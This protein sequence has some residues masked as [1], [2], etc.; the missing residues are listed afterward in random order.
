MANMQQA[1]S[2]RQNAGQGLLV[3][4][5]LFIAFCLLTPAA[6]A[7]VGNYEG[8]PVAS[9][10]VTLENT[11]PD[12]AAQA[13]FKSMLKIVGGSEYSAVKAR[14]SLHDLFASGRVASARV[15]IDETQTGCGRPTPIRVRFIVQRQIVIAG[16]TIRIAAT[17][18]TPVARD[19]NRPRLNLP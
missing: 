10:E 17:T 15:E 2:R 18:G 13:E 8:R 16:V 9:V 1:E 11:P 14:Q 4:S 5:F 3:F 19:E 12:A 6:F 7:Q